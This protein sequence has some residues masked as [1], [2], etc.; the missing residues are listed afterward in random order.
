[1][2]ETLQ[3]FD[4]QQQEE[5]RRSE[6][7]RALEAAQVKDQAAVDDYHL[8]I[9]LAAKEYGEKELAFELGIDISTLSN[10]T[11]CERGRGYPQPRLLRKLRRKISWFA[12]WEADDAGYLPPQRKDAEI[13]DAAACDE[14]ER[15][16]LPELGKKQQDHLRAIL[17]RRRSRK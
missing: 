1:M 3:L 9:K 12:V 4:K 14:I 16:V 15:D 6:E 11:S 5:K 10:M 17:R 13:D 7:L 2:A 8:R